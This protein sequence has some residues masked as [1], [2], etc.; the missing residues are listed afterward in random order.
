MSSRPGANRRPILDD[1]TDVPAESDATTRPGTQRAP[2]GREGGAPLKAQPTLPLTQGELSVEEAAELAALKMQIQQTVN[3]QCDGYKEKCL[4]RRIAVRMRARGVHRYADYAALL[5]T[6][7]REYERL[8]DTLT[9]N[10]SK[11]FRNP[12]VWD[13]IAH[14]VLPDLYATGDRVLHAWSA[15]TASGEE[16][17]SMAILAYEFAREHGQPSN[18]LRVLGTDI[19][20]ASLDFARRGEYTD[21]AMTDID[22][23]VRERWFDYNGVYQ[24]RPDPRWL[25]RFATLD[26]MRD[27]FPSAQHIIFCRNVIIYFERSVQEELFR[28]FHAALRP[29]GYLVLGKVEALF[30]ASAALFHTVANR[31]RV[32]RKP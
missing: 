13:V 7:D 4:R 28:R 22:P 30:G 25:V 21:F 10:V 18:R 29:G 3:F 5:R 14:R 26:L 11:F 23:A 16:A 32:F 27:E 15:G 1:R 8:V 24:L 19:D 9:I 6:D 20:Q 31:Q 17:Y 12:D 2:I